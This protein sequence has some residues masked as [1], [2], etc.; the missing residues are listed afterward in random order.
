MRWEG[1]KLSDIERR[2][3]E[4]EQKILME[5]YAEVEAQPERYKYF[6][7]FLDLLDERAERIRCI[8]GGRWAD[9]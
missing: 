3:S 8:L 9:G 2:E 1:I 6:Q 4:E 7:R 5:M